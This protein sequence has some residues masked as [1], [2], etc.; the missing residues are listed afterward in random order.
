MP[1]VATM[2][3]VIHLLMTQLRKSLTHYLGNGISRIVLVTTHDFKR[4]SGFIGNGIEADQGVSHWDGEQRLDHV[5]PCRDRFIVE[6]GPLEE[7]LRSK[8]NI[9]PWIG[10]IQRFL[11][12]HRYKDLNQSK[13]IVTKHALRGVT[14]DLIT[15][16]TYRHA[17]ALQLNMDHRHTIDEQEQVTPP[18]RHEILVLRGTLK[19]WLTHNLI[20]T[21]TS[22][23]LSTTIDLQ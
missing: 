6:V 13:Y 16:L 14:H 4:L 18:C 7:E 21:L 20:T 12:C 15:G 1:Y 19:T 23:N 9:R 22:S 17:T 10:K 11:R 8:V 2:L 3:R 5:I